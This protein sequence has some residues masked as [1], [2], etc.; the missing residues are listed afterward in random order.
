MIKTGSFR[1]D[2]ECPLEEREEN[3]RRLIN[4][5]VND[6]SNGKMLSNKLKYSISSLIKNE[7]DQED[8]Y[9]MFLLCLVKGKAKTYKYEIKDSEN[10]FKNKYLMRWVDKVIKNTSIN[11]L[12]DNYNRPQNK[13]KLYFHNYSKLEYEKG[14]HFIDWTFKKL[15][16]N[17][18]EESIKNE[19]AKSVRSNLRN[20]EQ[21]YKQVLINRFYKKN[22]SYREISDRLNLPIGTV[23][24]RI[25]NAKSALSRL[26]KVVSLV[27]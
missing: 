20:I 4:L 11:F 10:P 13:Y 19:S 15:E 3:A 2:K 1:D 5:F 27:S 9:S 16:G 6:L 17:P 26:E 8:V 12:R 7:H 21:G 18:E 25:S 14:K 22:S 23:K 24:S